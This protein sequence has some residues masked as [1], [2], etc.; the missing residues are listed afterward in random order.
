MPCVYKVPYLGSLWCQQ[1]I[2]GSPSVPWISCGFGVP[3]GADLWGC[4]HSQAGPGQV[5]SHCT[6]SPKG[7]ITQVAFPLFLSFITVQN[8]TEKEDLSVCFFGHLW[9]WK[10]AFLETKK[11]LGWW[12]FLFIKHWAVCAESQHSLGA[13][14]A[15]SCVLGKTSPCHCHFLL[16]THYNH[17][18]IPEDQRNNRWGGKSNQRPKSGESQFP[19][20]WA[21]W[22]FSLWLPWIP[23]YLWGLWAASWSAWLLG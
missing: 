8:F 11:F 3:W 14:N 15:V 7:T 18:N 9:G 13:P 16:L 12:E 5:S 17:P 19:K 1:R 22:K 4:R 10:G 6:F 23:R 21:E 20:C 2:Q